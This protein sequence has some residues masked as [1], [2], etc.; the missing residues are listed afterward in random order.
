MHIHHVGMLQSL[1]SWSKVMRYHL[2]ELQRSGHEL[3]SSPVS[4]NRHNPS[5]SLPPALQGL[6]DSPPEEADVV[7][8]F[9]EPSEY[10]HIETDAPLVGFLVYEAT[11]W[12][13]E[14]V[15]AAREHLALAVVPSAFSARGLIDSGFPAEDVVV[16]TEGYDREVY[17]PHTT[18]STPYDDDSFRPL[19]V[20]TPARRKGL[21]ILLDAVP[22]AFDPTDDVELLLKLV[23]YEGEL[24]SRPHVLTDWRERCTSLR[25]AGYRIQLETGILSEPALADLYR[26]ADVLCLPTR[27]EAFGLT[28]LEAL[29]CGTPPIVTNWSG[30]VEYS[31]QE[32]SFLLTEYESTDATERILIQP[33]RI[34]E[35]ARMV[36]PS[37]DELASTLRSATDCPELVE[38]RSEVAPQQVGDFTW[39]AVTERLEVAL[40]GLC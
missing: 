31:D 19:F 37:V 5:V 26:G 22:R 6:A 20:G 27:G 7:M 17:H 34:P 16:V 21:D 25:E 38:V 29:A 3:S 4:E 24:S 18:D 12:P 1:A 10:H 11:R 40:R 33:P 13:E 28:G 23:P 9:M 30:P 35:S 14:W 32:S 2:V 15:N 39:R 36:S 8:T